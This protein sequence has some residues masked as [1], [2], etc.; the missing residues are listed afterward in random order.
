MLCYGP[1]DSNMSLK[2]EVQFLDLG[3]YYP[4]TEKK[5]QFGAV[6]YIITMYSAKSYVK[7]WGSVQILGGPNPPTSQWLHPY[8]P[9]NARHNFAIFLCRKIGCFFI[10]WIIQ[11][12]L[13]HNLFALSTGI[14]TI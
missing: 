11:L 8:A 12:I 6:G 2:L 7:T 3:Y 5:L 1:L 14:C 10:R 4:S 13:L 9:F